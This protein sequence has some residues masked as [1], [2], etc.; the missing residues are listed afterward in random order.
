[1]LCNCLVLRLVYHRHS[2]WTVASTN[3]VC[4]CVCLSVCLSVCLALAVY[5]WE[6]N[7]LIL[8]W[9]LLLNLVLGPI[10]CVEIW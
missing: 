10:D 7:E 2:L 5:C 1:M 4:V 9:F 3:F 8:M 6:T